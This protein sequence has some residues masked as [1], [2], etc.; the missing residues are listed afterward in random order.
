MLNRQ[1]ITSEN[2][3]NCRLK[4]SKH[5]QPLIGISRDAPRTES[6]KSMSD[7]YSKKP[8]VPFTLRNE[9]VHALSA[10]RR[11]HKWRLQS[12]AFIRLLP[13]L[14][15][16][17]TH[18][19][20]VYRPLQFHKGSQDFLRAHGERCPVAARIHNPDRLPFAIHSCDH[21]KLKPASWRLSAMISHFFIACVFRTVQNRL[22]RRLTQFK[23]CAH[24]L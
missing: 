24:F 15:R 21:P 11:F 20:F 13:P 5:S 17:Q 12:R 3:T 8:I 18:R 4:F 2:G 7:S 1:Q 9:W 14:L 16:Y 23:L 19:E 6:P 22:R 10:G